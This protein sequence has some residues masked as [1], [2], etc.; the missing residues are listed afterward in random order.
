MATL[1]E[2]AGFGDVRTMARPLDAAFDAGSTLAMGT[3][4]G[5]LGW[6]YARLDAP[7]QA[8]RRRAAARLASLPAEDFI[9]R[10]EVLL[11]TANRR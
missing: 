9:D 5:R 6:R 4:F 10:S 1:L 8:V 11:T 7:A 3:G 2:P